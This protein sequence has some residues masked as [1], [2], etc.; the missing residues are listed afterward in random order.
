MQKSGVGAENQEHVV[1]GISLA[2]GKGRVDA[3]G[4]KRWRASASSRPEMRIIGR[5]EKNEEKHGR[6]KENVAFFWE[7]GEEEWIEC[8]EFVY[9]WNEGVMRFVGV[10]TYSWRFS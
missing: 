9:A 4:G 6:G 2:L 10:C 3:T 8:R 5:K 1:V 7:P